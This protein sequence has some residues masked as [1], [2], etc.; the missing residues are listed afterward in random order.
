MVVGGLAVGLASVL[1]LLAVLL[2][3][4]RFDRHVP[5]RDQVHLV[6]TQYNYNG[7][8]GEW[9]QAAPLILK[10]ALDGSGLALSA[11]TFLPLTRHLVVE[12]VPHLV[13]LVL[14]DP[15]FPVVFGLGPAQQGDLQ[16]ALRRP[17][18]IALTASTARRL[19]GH[20]QAVGRPV[21]TMGRSFRVAAV[22]EDPPEASTFS[23][24]ALAG[25]SSAA[26]TEEVRQA[27]YLQG[28]AW[29]W[30]NGG[31]FIRL[32]PG[33]TVQQVEAFAQ[34]AVDASPLS[35]RERPEVLARLG[36]Q[37]LMN[38]RLG[39][40]AEAYLD[41]SV[42]ASATTDLHG[43]LQML[44]ALGGI[45]AIILVLSAV[46]YVNLATVSTLRRQR[47][48]AMRKVLGARMG[49]VVGQLVSESIRVALLA[50]ALGYLLAVMAE[51]AF[52][53]LLG[54]P[55]NLMLTPGM[56]L[57][58]LG[59]GL[60]LG[61]VTGLYPAWMALRMRTA[62]ALSGRLAGETASGLWLRRI[63]TVAQF[64]AAMVLC[65][66][67]LTVVWQTEHAQRQDPGFNPDG[68]WILDLPRDMSDPTTQALRDAVARMPGVS[69]VT[70]SWDAVAQYQTRI[71]GSL[72]RE[73]GPVA[74]VEYKGIRP[75]FFG[76][77]QVG[78][79]AGRVFDPGQ[80]DSSEDRIVLDTRA[81]QVLGFASP[82]SAI[83]QTVVDD[84]GGRFRI[85]G[86]ATTVQYETLR[87][88]P[89]PIVYTIQ[90]NTT[91]L[92]VRAGGDP[93][94]VRSGL[95]V[96][97]KQY[98]PQHVMRITAARE[99]LQLRYADDRRLAQA[100]ALGASLAFLMA[101]FG[102]YVLAAYSV[103]RRR[104]EVVL[105]KLFGAS[106]ADIALLLATELTMLLLVSAVVAAPVGWWGM[107]WYLNP[108]LDRSPMG[109][110]PLATAML[111]AAVVAIVSTARQAVAAMRIT[112]QLALRG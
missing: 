83:G 6:K 108:F 38:V 25:S 33:V 71:V 35:S 92:S 8:G 53:R 100:L 2:H 56:V 73:G 109:M 105:R 46:N 51:P 45:A 88:E 69:G 48:I 15:E 63:L 93:Q 87:Q 67:G 70:G 23:Y 42:S 28:E 102:V 49:Q 36:Q 82:A 11:S 17:D 20:A 90:S 91:T 10:A 44:Q 96:L 84:D 7:P 107:Q 4:L 52:G 50:T 27:N 72:Q 24:Q 65:A 32:S 79:I 89:N 59:L 22:L 77:Y 75:D 60:T 81:V 61:V 43:N 30:L 74:R 37:K 26:I 39:S 97:W 16:E 14:V 94:A 110:S 58:S 101:A 41:P 76:V 5:D 62:D 12:Q 66:G 1:L 29:G 19:F 95:Q 98:F 78:A 47:E 13:R 3:A 34:A 55:L 80:D 64:A 106:M 85:V 99:Y 57:A 18:A 103:Q 111:I 40:L 104:R 31:V 112:P 21:I 86:V 68:L 9:Q 54:Q